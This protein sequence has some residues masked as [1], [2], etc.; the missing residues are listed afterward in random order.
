MRQFIWFSLT[1]LLLLASGLGHANVWIDE[2][3]E[4]SPAFND[5]DTVQNDACDPG[6]A[7]SLTHNGSLTTADA[8]RGSQS[9]ELA[10]GESIVTDASPCKP[11]AGPFHYLQ[12][13]VKVASIP[14]AGT[15]AILHYNWDT[16]VLFPN[17]EEFSFFVAF[18]ST[19]SS[20]DIVAGED[21]AGATSAIIDTLPDTNT[22]KYITLQFQKNSDPSAADDVE[23]GQTDVPQGTYFYS[24]SSTPQMY[25][26]WNTLGFNP[27]HLG[28]SFTVNSGTL[29]LDHFYWEGAMV[30][31][32]GLEEGRKLRDPA[33]GSLLAV[34]HW[35]DY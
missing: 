5:L 21:L 16:D 6:T 29:L 23:L 2:S 13:A 33:T 27:A 25:I 10:A 26:P 1:L 24:S 7:T 19:G 15:M 31:D 3:F 9:Y 14:A 11:S 22:W 32:A 18:V 30:S 20:V 28:W 34:E 4:D 35:R 8:F 12:F 17:P